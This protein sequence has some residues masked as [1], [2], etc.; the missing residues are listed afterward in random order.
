MLSTWCWLC[1]NLLLAGYFLLAIWSRYVHKNQ[2]FIWYN[3]SCSKFH[4]CF[5]RRYNV[6]KSHKSDVILYRNAIHFWIYGYLCFASVL[7]NK[8][9]VCGCNYTTG[10]DCRIKPCFLNR[11]SP[12]R[13]VETIDCLKTSYWKIF[14]NILS[15]FASISQCDLKNWLHW[16][17]FLLIWNYSKHVRSVWKSRQEFFIS[18]HFSFIQM[19]YHHNNYI[20]YNVYCTRIT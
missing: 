10:F 8:G 15:N 11:A 12:S 20:K 16:Y 4:K 1:C 18:F 6:H 5:G 2:R 14:E 13:T 17:N 3:W 19:K 9:I 7:S